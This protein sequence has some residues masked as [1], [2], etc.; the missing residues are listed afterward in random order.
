MK[1]IIIKVHG[2]LGNQMFQYALYKELQ[3]FGF[4]TRL[5]VSWYKS[6]EM[7]HGFGGYQ[8]ERVFLRD[9]GGDIESTGLMK[10]LYRKV[11]RRIHR[12]SP[13]LQKFI[14]PYSY[15]TKE[16]GL[17]F[18][19]TC[20]SR[21]KAGKYNYVEGYWQNERWF[22][23]VTQA[24]SEDFTFKPTLSAVNRD[25]RQ[26]IQ[27]SMRDRGLATIGIHVRRY[28]NEGFDSSDLDAAWFDRA[29]KLAKD[30]YSKHIVY[31]FSDNIDWCRENLKVDGAVFV[32][33]NTAREDQYVDMELM[34][35]CDCN[36]I[37]NS[38]FSWW[39]AWLNPAKKE[40]LV[41]APR[42]WVF[43]SAEF[44]DGWVTI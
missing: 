2:G 5:D 10:S 29:L 31:V 13:R 3:F 23:D 6:Y 8:L 35:Y 1:K 22:D 28:A 43:A 41:I 9:E 26:T 36:I 12:V 16:A 17:S 24:V 30:R 38:S 20:F 19:E 34:S 32:D 14:S 27:H 37:S 40:K 44:P 15:F 4:D 21:M 39:G 11:V 7:P 25:C 42:D 18:D 33:W